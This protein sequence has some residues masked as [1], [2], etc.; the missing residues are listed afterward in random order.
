MMGDRHRDLLMQIATEQKSI[1]ANVTEIKADI[2]TLN[3][4]V[5]GLELNGA[6]RQKRIEHIEGETR[7]IKNALEK[8][9]SVHNDRISVLEKFRWYILAILGFIAALIPIAASLAGM[10]NAWFNHRWAT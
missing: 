3:A 5:K 6:I 8:G 1:A 9:L 4:S 7:E 2:K 10:V